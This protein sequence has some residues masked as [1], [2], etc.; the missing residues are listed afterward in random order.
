VQPA[1]ITNTT[2]ALAS[3]AEFITRL[4]MALF[5]AVRACLPPAQFNQQPSSCRAAVA[6]L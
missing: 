2:A 5:L 1:S 4:A 6:V 3:F